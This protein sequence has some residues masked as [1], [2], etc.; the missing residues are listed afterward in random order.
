MK[1][2]EEAIKELFKRQLSFR[3]EEDQKVIIDFIRDV[4][5]SYVA[6]VEVSKEILNALQLEEKDE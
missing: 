6:I 4:A 5:F 3:T 1:N 2:N